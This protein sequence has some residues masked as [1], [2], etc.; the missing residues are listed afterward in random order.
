MNGRGGGDGVQAGG[1]RA[2][3][4]FGVSWNRTADGTRWAVVPGFPHGGR[5]LISGR[6]AGPAHDVDGHKIARRA[7][8]GECDYERGR[9]AG[10]AVGL[11]APVPRS[12]VRPRDDILADRYD[13]IYRGGLPSRVREVA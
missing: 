13:A 7:W 10:A 1:P 9:G 11:P 4:G 3:A 6:W 5:L 8:C 12:D 2:A